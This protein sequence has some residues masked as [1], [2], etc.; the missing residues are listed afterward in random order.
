MQSM[1]NFVRNNFLEVR[2]LKK[3]GAL[4]TDKRMMS[5]SIGFATF[6]SSSVRYSSI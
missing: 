2:P 5:V 4:F 3:M 1:K 6:P